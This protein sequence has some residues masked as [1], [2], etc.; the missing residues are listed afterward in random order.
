MNFYATLVENVFFRIGDL[1]NNSEFVKQLKLQRTYNHFSSEELDILQRNKL[2]AMLQHATQTC[3][4]Y[5]PYFNNKNDNP[6]EWIRQ[7]PIITKQITVRQTDDLISNKFKKQKLIKYESSGSSGLRSIVYLDKKEQ[8]I[9]RAILI[10]WWEWNGYK[11]GKKI[12][13]TGMSP[14]R[15]WLKKTK[16]ILLSTYYFNAFGLSENLILKA[17]HDAKINPKKILIGYASSLHELAR[18]ANIHQVDVRFDTAI[19]LGDKLFDH[20]KLELEKAFNC[21]VVENYG[22]NEGIMIAQKK[23][24]NYFYQYTPNVFIEIVNDAGDT[25]QDGYL[26]RIIATKLDGFAM[27][28]IRYDT[29]DLGIRLPLAKYPISR[30]FAFP[31]IEK[32]IGRNTDVIRTQDGKTLIVHTFTGIFEFFA[33]IKQFQIIQH[34]AE[35][36]EINFIPSDEYKDDIVLDKIEQKIFEQTESVIKI[37]WHRVNEIAPSKSGKPQLVINYLVKNSL[38]EVI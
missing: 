38:T 33:E 37:I 22:L 36:I 20:Y 5:N 28:L 32:V 11:F 1:I 6:Y 19:S 23:D 29:G 3:T 24:L 15:G 10:N 18:V 9:I 8:S 17:L 30:D 16:D 26:G 31:L 2:F 4:F 21:H 14:K 35:E 27:P 34:R 13:Q 7:F 25:V 12:F